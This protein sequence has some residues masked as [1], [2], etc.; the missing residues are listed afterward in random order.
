MRAVFIS[1]RREDVE[2]HAGRL[3][4]DLT[5]Q[6]GKDAVFMDVAGIEPGRDFRRAIDQQVASCGVLLALIGKGW[7]DAKNEAGL[8]RLDDPADFVRLETATALKRDI[9]VIPVLVHGGRMPRA[10]ELPDDLKDLAYR[11]AVE[12][13]HTRW[14]SDVQLLVKALCPYVGYEKDEAGSVNVA[15]GLESTQ[16]KF[17]TG[18]TAPT[19]GTS[20]LGGI[21]QATV[22]ERVK[23]P[24]RAI[25]VAAVVM[26]VAAGG[27]VS[28][29]KFSAEKAAAE[30]AEA[31]AAAA[32]AE[33]VAAQAAAEKAAAEEAAAQ[34]AAAQKAAAD[35]AQAE[36]AAAKAEAAAAQAA[37]EKAAAEKVAAQKAA[38]E[39]LAA[40]RKPQAL[41]PQVPP[42]RL[43]SFGG[44][45]ELIENTYQG[46][47]RQIKTPQRI[48]I[49]QDRD[50][51]TIN[52]LQ[53]KI[54]SKGAVIYK[55]FHGNYGHPVE[56]EDQA[57]LV[58]TFTW[59]VQ[60]D[61]LVWETTFNYKR[62]YLGH[63]LGTE[64]RVM[65][66][67]RVAP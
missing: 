58:E 34:K 65:K 17:R 5:T 27:Y 22:P 20:A 31:E 56:T 30:K 18:S 59:I 33:V 9:P 23:T 67:K 14:D 44:T 10:E 7:L 46:A 51:V 35:K 12:L 54:T 61:T 55:K 63:S 25:V 15:S 37:A 4:Q 29:E 50:L 52:G 39:K 26:A 3:F 48:T 21:G 60:G 6:F 43:P 36:A 28:Y 2:G 57:D 19:S 1:Y 66:Y 24:W 11:N 40:A 8:R 32:K 53:V 62:P 13:S 47:V 49:T 38:A 16:G 45:W 64:V 42:S 41:G